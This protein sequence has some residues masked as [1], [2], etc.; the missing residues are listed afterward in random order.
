MERGFARFKKKKNNQMCNLCGC[1]T[2]DPSIL[3]KVGSISIPSL[4]L[5]QAER[6]MLT[7]SPSRGLTR[8]ASSLEKSFRELWTR[9]MGR[10]ISSGSRGGRQAWQRRAC[11]AA[12]S[13]ERGA[14]DDGDMAPNAGPVYAVADLSRI[15]KVLKSEPSM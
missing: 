3:P 6:L 8:L 12:V 2:I 14:R 13:A 9:L 1:S 5:K 11:A 15:S 7:R 10:Q 4:H